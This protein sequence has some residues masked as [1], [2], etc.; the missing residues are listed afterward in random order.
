MKDATVVE[1]YVPLPG[2]PQRWRWSCTVCGLKVPGYVTEEWA[3]RHAAE[4]AAR[5]GAE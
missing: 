1:S 3:R 4:H 5:H 2:Q